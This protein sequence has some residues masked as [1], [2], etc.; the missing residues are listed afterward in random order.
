MVGW[1]DRPDRADGTVVERETMTGPRTSRRVARVVL[2]VLVLGMGAVAL[3]TVPAVW[4]WAAYSGKWEPIVTMQISRPKFGSSVIGMPRISSPDA[5]S[6]EIVST[7]YKVLMD[8]QPMDSD[9][10][11]YFK[12]KQKRL[13]WLP[14]KDLLFLQIGKE[15]FQG[16]FP[17]ASG[18]MPRVWGV[19][20]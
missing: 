5:L 16:L 12:A 18:Q 2:L 15:E 13:H 1:R 10:H 20:K 14:G 7:V 19:R 8:T 4:E 6:W 17:N 11:S 3:P 9:T